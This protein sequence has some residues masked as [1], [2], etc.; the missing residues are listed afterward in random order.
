MNFFFRNWAMLYTFWNDKQLPWLQNNVAIPKLNSKGAFQYQEE[1][2]RVTMMMPVEL[3]LS[4]HHHDI[5]I[6]ELRDDLWAPVFV[7]S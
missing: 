2:V 5:A 3:S 7:E 4:F 1:I 6:I